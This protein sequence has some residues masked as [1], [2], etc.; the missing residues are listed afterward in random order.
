MKLEVSLNSKK[1]IDVVA[2][3]DGLTIDLELATLNMY[4]DLKLAGLA[5]DVPDRART[6]MVGKL[7][8]QISDYAR[9]IKSNSSHIESYPLT[10]CGFT[11]NQLRTSW[12]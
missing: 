1:R 2:S 3:K 5:A 6:I 11:W 4:A 8:K 7:S 9:E 10:R 12:K